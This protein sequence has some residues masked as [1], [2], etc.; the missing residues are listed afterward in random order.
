MSSSFDRVKVTAE[1]EDNK[2]GRKR[3]NGQTFPLEKDP[4][5]LNAIFLVNG[6]DNP[7][8]NLTC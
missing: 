6:I 8:S 1:E 5:F 7:P 4:L 3:F 2:I